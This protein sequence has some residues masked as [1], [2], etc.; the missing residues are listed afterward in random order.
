[1]VLYS[2]KKDKLL[3]PKNILPEKL[4]QSALHMCSNRNWL[5]SGENVPYISAHGC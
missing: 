3:L 1:M 4:I 5:F 2:R